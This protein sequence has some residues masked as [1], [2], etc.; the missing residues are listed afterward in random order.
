MRRQY[1]IRFRLPVEYRFPL[2]PGYC[3]VRIE[4]QWHQIKGCPG[5]SKLVKNTGSEEP[6]H[7]ADVVIDAM[8]ARERDGAID[9]PNEK[10]GRLATA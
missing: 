7:I 5:V 10:R 6:A 3:F 1:Q 2:F 9:L 8:K 4:L